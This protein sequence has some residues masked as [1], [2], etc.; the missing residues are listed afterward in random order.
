MKIDLMRLDK[1][2]AKVLEYFENSL[3]YFNKYVQE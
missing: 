1:N 3:N 2:E